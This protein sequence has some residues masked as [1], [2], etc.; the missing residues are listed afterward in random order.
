MCSQNCYCARIHLW[1]MGVVVVLVI[2]ISD[3]LLW[4]ATDGTLK[5]ISNNRIIH[6]AFMEIKLSE[7]QRVTSL[8]LAKL[9]DFF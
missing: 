4:V 9:L 8:E 7:N 1:I 2:G 3:I 6:S 5:R